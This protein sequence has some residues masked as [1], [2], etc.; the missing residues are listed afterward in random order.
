MIGHGNAMPT[1]WPD[2]NIYHKRSRTSMCP[3][4]EAAVLWG[5]VACGREIRQRRRES[6]AF[7]AGGRIPSHALPPRGGFHRGPT[8]VERDPSTTPKHTRAPVFIRSDGVRCWKRSRASGFDSPAA[9]RARHYARRVTT[10]K[11][12]AAVNLK[13]RALGEL[14]VINRLIGRATWNVPRGMN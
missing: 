9:H 13:G 4:G 3:P 5:R 10:P 12:T 11:A 8:E 6:S 7:R 2:A 1:S 14:R